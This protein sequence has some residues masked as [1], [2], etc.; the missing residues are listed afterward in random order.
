MQ[1]HYLHKFAFERCD[2]SWEVANYP[3][4]TVEFHSAVT[5]SECGW[6]GVR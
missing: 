1:I 2:H 5:F 6:A 4:G 3:D